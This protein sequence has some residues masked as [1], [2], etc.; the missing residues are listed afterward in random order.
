MDMDRR[1]KK[2]DAGRR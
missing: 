1:S 2:I